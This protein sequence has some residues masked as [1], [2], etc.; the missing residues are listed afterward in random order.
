MLTIGIIKGLAL[1][2]GLLVYAMATTQVTRRQRETERA[3][4]AGK[5]R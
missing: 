1:L 2:F 3:T 5:A 4:S